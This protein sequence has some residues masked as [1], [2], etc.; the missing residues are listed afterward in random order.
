MPGG[1]DLDCALLNSWGVSDVRVVGLDVYDLDTDGDGIACERDIP[2]RT[3]DVG[4]AIARIAGLGAILANPILLALALMPVRWI[5][6]L[7]RAA[8]DDAE[9]RSVQLNVAMTLFSAFTLALLSIF[10]FSVVGIDN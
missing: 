3:T 2:A 5:I 1:G 10:L 7:Y 4:D 6:Q 8:A 9:R